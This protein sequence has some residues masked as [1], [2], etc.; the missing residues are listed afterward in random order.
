MI[1]GVESSASG[2][3]VDPRADGLAARLHDTE[4]R[5]RLAEERL[6]EAE[7][8][9]AE[10]GELREGLR[11]ALEDL[12]AQEARHAERVDELERALELSE[13]RAEHLERVRAE[14]QDSVSWKVTTPLRAAK[15]RAGGGGADGPGAR[16]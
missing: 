2:A 10:A 1:D 11:A 8:L 14:L 4:A 9:G 7:R 12:A 3:G 15:R 13:A 16:T 6:L 5:L